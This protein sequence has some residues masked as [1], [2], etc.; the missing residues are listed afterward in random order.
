MVS[1]MFP[2]SSLR[3]VLYIIKF[4]AAMGKNRPV[5]GNALRLGYCLLCRPLRRFN[6]HLNSA[7]LQIV[8]LKEFS[9]T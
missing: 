8:L 1:P 5:I 9:K 2:S 3:E 6:G 7:D 4:I